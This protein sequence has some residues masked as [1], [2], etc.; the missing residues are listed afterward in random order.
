[1][2]KVKFFLFLSYWSCYSNDL[3]RLKV[4][5]FDIEFAKNPEVKKF[6]E[7]YQK[8]S[9]LNTFTKE[10]SYSNTPLGILRLALLVKGVNYLEGLNLEDLEAAFRK[11]CR[12]RL[13]LTIR[14]EALKAEGC[15]CLKDE[16]FKFLCRFT[17]KL[18]NH[19][20]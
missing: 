6:K 1:M 4:K 11:A 19:E 15:N 12:I 10:K 16:E 20:E 3:L 2:G 7:K 14:Q 5:Y 18:I 17:T 13:A 9:D 8:N